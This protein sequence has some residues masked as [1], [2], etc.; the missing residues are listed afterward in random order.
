VYIEGFGPFEKAELEV[1]PLTVFMGR[2]S[3][4]K[5]ML[6]RLLWAL[7]SA[8][9]ALEDVY[10]LDTVATASRVVDR[11]RAGEDPWKDFEHTVRVYCEKVLV[12]AVRIS[13][14]DNLRACFWG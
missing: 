1:R 5:S 10:S 4:G 11:V 6:L 9:P 7:S 13:I 8:A 3:T 12:E 2:N 14:E